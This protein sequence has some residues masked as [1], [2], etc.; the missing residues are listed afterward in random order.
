[1]DSTKL[2]NEVDYGQELDDLDEEEIVEFSGDDFIKQTFLDEYD[3]WLEKCPTSRRK[4]KGVLQG[5]PV[6]KIKEI[7]TTMKIITFQ[8]PGITSKD[9]LEF[10]LYYADYLE[11]FGDH[12][13]LITKFD[14]KLKDFISI[15]TSFMKNFDTTEKKLSIKEILQKC[16]ETYQEAKKS[17]ITDVM[18]KSWYERAADDILATELQYKKIWAPIIKNFISEEELR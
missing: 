3:D 1:M 9:T 15:L 18:K 8:M 11:E 13:L 2:P 17:S 16:S 7:D 12:R 4:F 6:V 10:E 14:E 5:P